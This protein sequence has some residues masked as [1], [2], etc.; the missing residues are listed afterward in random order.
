[1]KEQ[2]ENTGKSI[3]E[4]VGERVIVMGDM[5]A[6]IGVLGEQMNR[7]GAMLV[8]FTG[9]MD[10]ENLNE[11]LTEGCVTWSAR[12]LKESAIDYMLVNGRMRETVRCMWVDEDGRIDIVSDH[13][14][15][16]VEC[17]LCSKSELRAKLK[18]KWRNRGCWLGELSGRP[19]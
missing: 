16:V 11:T 6:H 1:M 19:K 9:E 7:N 3:L 12:K 17:M 13:N 8:E 14:M 18:K 4:H 2:R 10:L 5:N 15:L